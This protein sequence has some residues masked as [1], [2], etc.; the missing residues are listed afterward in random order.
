MVVWFL[1]LLLYSQ[2]P[3]EVDMAKRWWLAWV[4]SVSFVVEIWTQIF[5]VDIP[6][7]CKLQGKDLN[8]ILQSW[9]PCL[10]W[11]ESQPSQWLSHLMGIQVLMVAK[12]PLL[13]PMGARGTISSL[14]LCQA[15]VYPMELLGSGLAQ[16]LCYG[17]LLGGT[18]EACTGLAKIGL[19]DCL[20]T[21]ASYW[22]WRGR[23]LIPQRGLYR[24]REKNELQIEKWRKWEG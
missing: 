22:F 15:P 7:L 18:R 12:R 2:R 8:P 24:L 13:C 21:I 20:K 4:S 23:V 5:I 16:M 6:N 11:V 14:T 9:K 10:V 3:C 1:L 19:Q 17:H